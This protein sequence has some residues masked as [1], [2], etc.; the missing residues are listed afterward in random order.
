[1][2]KSNKGFTPTL[3]NGVVSGAFSGRISLSQKIRGSIS[4]S[5]VLKRH[6][7]NASP[8]FSAGFTLVELLVVIAIIGILAS[9]VLVSLNSARGKARDAR[10]VSDLHQISLAMENYY[11]A[12]SAYPNSADWATLKTAMATYMTVPDDPLNTSANVYT[13]A[14]CTSAQKYVLKAVL[15]NTGNPA[16]NNDLDGT[17]CTLDCADASKYYCTGVQN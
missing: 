12:N 9:V 5:G 8:F 14:A 15:E 6:N 13:T 7:K 1:M 2:K 17:V 16:F 10:R 4:F 11:D 3:E